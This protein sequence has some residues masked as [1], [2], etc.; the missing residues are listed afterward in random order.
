MIG[1][2]LEA[3]CYEEIVHA[4]AD[5]GEEIA[6]YHPVAIDPG[7]LLLRMVVDDRAA[8]A[9]Q[10]DQTKIEGVV[11]VLIHAFQ[12]TM[13][14]GFETGVGRSNCEIISG[15]VDVLGFRANREPIGKR[16]AYLMR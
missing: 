16:F 5:A 10:T 7:E 11:L 15:I 9:V 1:L 8:N 4:L 14:D 2:I 3:L 6:V 13:G 12:F